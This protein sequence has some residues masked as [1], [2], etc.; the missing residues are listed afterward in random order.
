MKKII[1]Q[2][3]FL[4]FAVILTIVLSVTNLLFGYPKSWW[5]VA[6]PTIVGVIFEAIAWGIAYA[7]YR[8]H[9]AEIQEQAENEAMRECLQGA[10]KRASEEIKRRNNQ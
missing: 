9:K 7:Y 1:K 5:G 8:K 6:A 10:L 2:H 4:T 3:Q